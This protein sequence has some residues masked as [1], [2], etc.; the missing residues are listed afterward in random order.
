VSI[1]ILEGM[2]NHTHRLLGELAAGQHGVFSRTEARALGLSDTALADRLVAG[3]YR[4]MAP[5]VFAVVGTV[6]TAQQRMV[7][8]VKSFRSLAA[9]SHQTAAELWGLTQRGI[10]GVEITTTRWDRVHR[11]EVTVHE[12][13]DLVDEDVTRLDG[14]P[15]TSAVR[16]VVDLGASNKW[17]V[18]A[19]LEQGIRQGLFSLEQVELLVARVGR[20][21]RRGVGVIRPLL[22]VRRRWDSVTESALED[23]FRKLVRRNGLPDPVTQFTLRDDYGTFICRSDFAYPGS[24]LLIELDSEAHHLDRLTFRR[25]RSK[26]NRA[27]VL[28][29][30]TLRYTWWDLSEEPERVGVEVRR[31]LGPT[32]ARSVL[33]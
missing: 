26:Q 4:R 12:S 32:A 30:T 16:T 25:D 22:Q 3:R 21:G 10:R 20:R 19:A 17:A 5:G 31:A 28:G 14:V 7:G 13:L 15:I 24:R 1:V 29:W 6:D 33:A 9:V 11:S 18:E 2:E 23:E 8:A 27:T